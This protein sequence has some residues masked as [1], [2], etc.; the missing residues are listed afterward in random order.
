MDMA[1]TSGRMPAV[2]DKIRNISNLCRI[3]NIEKMLSDCLD[4]LPQESA[5]NYVGELNKNDIMH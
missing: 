2:I 4:N 1:I 5:I 3:S